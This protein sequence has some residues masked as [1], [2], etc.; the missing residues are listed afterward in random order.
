MAISVGRDPFARGEYLRRVH[1]A[2]ECDWCGQHQKRLYTYVW[3]DDDK[4]HRNTDHAHAQAK[5]FCNFEC[6]KDYH[7]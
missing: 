4:A 1:G 7:S 6:F 3:E 2:G 5:L